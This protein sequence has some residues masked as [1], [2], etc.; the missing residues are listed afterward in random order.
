MKK[1]ILI[2]GIQPS[3]R[4]HLGNYL[5]ALK[6]FV[7]LQNSGKYDCY[8]FIADLHSITEDFN[9]KTKPEQI[10][11]VASTFIAAGLDPKKSTIFLQSQVPASTELAWILSSIAPFG[12]LRRMTQFKEKGNVTD[13]EEIQAN[14]GL[15]TYPLLMAA[16][17]LLYDANVV[18]VGDDQLQHLE[19]TRTLARKFNNHFGEIFIEPKALLTPTPR[20]MSLSDP[21]RKMSKSE[22]S[23]C[24]F[25][26]DEPGVIEAK[27]KK[28][29]TDSGNV[30][31]YDPLNKAG[32]SNLLSIM[33]TLSGKSTEALE[34]AFKG[35]NYGELKHAVS[36][37]VADYF[38]PLRD[39]KSK[40]LKNPRAMA[41][42]ISSASK[43]TAKLAAIKLTSVKKLLGLGI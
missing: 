32:V 43:K 31:K 29:V 34:N 38:K 25:I 11:E 30:I 16:D 26:D 9:P 3:G 27:L 13:G 28:A 24:L 39:K 5:G 20:L 10:L 18:P 19:L 7:E 23:G 12:E 8:F 4:L 42:I 15:F 33:S 17:I 1:P 22:T 37:T 14:V 35:Q 6:N 2:S 41:K 36:D 21:T 40:L